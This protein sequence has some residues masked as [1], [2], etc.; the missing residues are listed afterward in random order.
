MN[1][2]SQAV[3]LI[4]CEGLLDTHRLFSAPYNFLNRI[5]L[6]FQNA[7]VLEMD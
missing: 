4:H 6:V 1:T 2:L 3:I 5:K 7:I